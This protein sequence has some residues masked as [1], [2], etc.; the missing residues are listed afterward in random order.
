MNKIS[1][2]KRRQYSVRKKVVGTKDCPRLAVFRS[3]KY[4]YAQVIDDGTGKTLAFESDLKLKEKGT[5]I[6]RA[7][8]VG[9]KIAEK[10][11]KTGIKKIVF[12]RGGFL[13][14]GRVAKLAE[15]AREGGLN[16]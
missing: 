16:F 6:D 4:I 9:K 12:D 2:K 13:Y 15:G 14:H 7:F 8:Q 10:A 3:G 11:L 5:K 1:P